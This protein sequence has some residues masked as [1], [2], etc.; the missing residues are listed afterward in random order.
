MVLTDHVLTALLNGAKLHAQDDYDGV[1]DTAVV[2]LYQNDVIPTSKFVWDDLAEADYTGYARS[3][4]IA[5]GTVKQSSQTM[6]PVLPADK[7]NFGCTGGDAQ[8]VA[9]YAI[10]LP[11]TPPVLLAIQPFEEPETMEPGGL[12]EIVPRMAFS[13]SAPVP[14]GDVTLT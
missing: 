13:P 5:W 10:I 14:S 8:T 1:L 6:L 3:S 4:A 2:A 12:L 11:S 7:K 9:G